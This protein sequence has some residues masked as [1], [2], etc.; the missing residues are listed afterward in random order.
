[1]VAAMLGVRGENVVSRP[2]GC[3]PNANDTCER[4]VVEHVLRVLLDIVVVFL[5]GLLWIYLACRIISGSLRT[6]R[7]AMSDMMSLCCVV[8]S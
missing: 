3:E 6:L 7:N 8:L 2:H 1:V 4:V 5:Y